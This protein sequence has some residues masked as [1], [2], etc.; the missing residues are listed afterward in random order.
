MQQ[1]K[2]FSN[3]DLDN[4][5]KLTPIV[6]VSDV[7]AISAIADNYALLDSLSCIVRDRFSRNATKRTVTGISNAIAHRSK[8]LTLGVA[9]PF[10]HL[11]HVAISSSVRDANSETVMSKNSFLGLLDFLIKLV[12]KLRYGLTIKS[13]IAHINTTK[14]LSPQ[15]LYR[16][17]YPEKDGKR[18]YQTYEEYTK[19]KGRSQS[20]SFA[21][22]F[23]V[24]MGGE[25]S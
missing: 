21:M 23:H 3:K 9:L 15:M 2:T 1:A 7:L 4:F 24:C 20:P 8:L 22:P 5:Q 12:I 6:G 14:H 18:I 11:D 16:N 10:S 25:V 13:I 17:L 19:P